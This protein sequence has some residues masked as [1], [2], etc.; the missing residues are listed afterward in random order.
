MT[1]ENPEWGFGDFDRGVA[2]MRFGQ[3]IPH[4]PE[5]LPWAV[6]AKVRGDGRDRG[7]DHL[8]GKPSYLMPALLPVSER[9]FATAVSRHR[10]QPARE[11][12]ELE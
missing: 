2:S 5:V 11:S 8:S 4:N 1:F 3:H 10:R 6:G 12:R 7:D 9:L